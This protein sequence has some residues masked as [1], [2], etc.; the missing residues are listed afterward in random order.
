[1]S[2]HHTVSCRPEH[3]HWGYFDAALAPVVTIASGD[4]VSIDCVSGGLDIVPKGDN[5]EILG[6]HIEILDELEPKLGAHILT[7]P[8]AVAG[9]EPGDVLQIDILSIDFRGR[10]G[11]T[12]A[13]A[14]WSAR[15][16]RT[17]RS[18]R[19]WHSGIDRQRGVS[20]C[21]WGARSTSRRFS[22]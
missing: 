15:F 21:R 11:V 22:G 9:A 19:V 4:T 12:P 10:T 5:F 13:S 6:D 14:R 20:R 16:P 7:G 17:S 1:M 3:C 8:V 18:A 2:Q